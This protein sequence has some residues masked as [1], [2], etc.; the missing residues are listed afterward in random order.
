[1]LIGM[2][3]LPLVD[4]LL[5]FLGAGVSAVLGVLAGCGTRIASGISGAEG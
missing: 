3:L 1:M 4:R 5:L 2:A